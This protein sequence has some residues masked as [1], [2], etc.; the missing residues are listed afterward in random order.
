MPNK[1][2]E[3]ELKKLTLIAWTYILFKE[4]K[5]SLTKCNKM[6]SKFEKLIS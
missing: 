4:G 1:N 5:I 6:I 2:S 3:L